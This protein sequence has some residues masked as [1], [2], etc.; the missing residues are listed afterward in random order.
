[1]GLERGDDQAP[2]RIEF[3]EYTPWIIGEYRG[4]GEMWSE[5]LLPQASVLVQ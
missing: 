4:H 2:C 1:M 5:H 3:D